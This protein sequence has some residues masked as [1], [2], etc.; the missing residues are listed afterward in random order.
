MI[1]ER[2]TLLP[3]CHPVAG[4]ANLSLVP[5]LELAGFAD[6]DVKGRYN[7]ADPTPDDDFLVFLA[8][9]AA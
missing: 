2:E 6:V 4:G 7:D 9:R 8:R 5:M 1:A 3:F